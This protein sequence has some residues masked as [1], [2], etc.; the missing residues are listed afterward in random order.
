[1]TDLKKDEDKI[2]HDLK[3]AEEDV[4]QGNLERAEKETEKALEEIKQAE[5]KH[6]ITINVD[7][8]D[9]QVHSGKWI[10]SDLKTKLGIDAAKVL[11]EITPHGLK[12]LDDN[13]EIKPHEH[14]KFITHA[15]SGGAA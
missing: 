4:E 13:A 7:G 8:E 5:K 10:V 12:D 6:L 9:L 2:L 15:R 14:D 11:A 3:H 1:M